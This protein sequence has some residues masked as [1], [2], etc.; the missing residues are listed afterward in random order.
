MRAPERN[1]KEH[2]VM[3]RVFLLLAT[4]AA[5]FVAAGC[6]WESLPDPGAA[7]H[8]SDDSLAATGRASPTL[9]PPGTSRTTPW[10]ACAT[11]SPAATTPP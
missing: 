5:F 6:D 2:I 9:V 4:L 10:P 8:V 7:G 1:C 11:V 3:K